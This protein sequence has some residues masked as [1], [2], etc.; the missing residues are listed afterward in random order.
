MKKVL[1]FEELD[2]MK[3]NLSSVEN[4]EGIFILDSFGNVIFAN[5]KAREIQSYFWREKIKRG[6][7]KKKIT[8]SRGKKKITIYPILE[9]S[10]IKFFFGIIRNEEEIE[11]MER[12]IK[13]LQRNFESF[14]ENMSHYFFNPIII[15]KGYLD[16]LMEGNLSK[17][18][19][20]NV[21][22][23]KEAVERIEKVVR[24]IVFEGRIEE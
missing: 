9:G 12:K 18:E 13:N 22:K 5:R 8:I 10:E 20:K 2:F 11:K 6:L 21:E 19:R 4:G 3:Q 15:A 23:V 17:K 1:A 16:L 14:K 24:N 7:E